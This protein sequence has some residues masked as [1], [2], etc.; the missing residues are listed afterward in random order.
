MG[1]WHEGLGDAVV[2]VDCQGEVHHIRWHRGRLRL[3]NHPDAAAEEVLAALSG[4]DDHHGP[5]RAAC[6]R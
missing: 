5:G 2:E 4:V 3:E 1:R 6:L